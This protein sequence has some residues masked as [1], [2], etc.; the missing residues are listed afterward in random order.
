M[1]KNQ[2][3]EFNDNILSLRDFV[4]LIEPILIEKH[5]KHDSKVKPI[6]LSAMVHQLLQETTE[7]ENPEEYKKLI[8]LKSE[9]EEI[10]ENQFSE[11][12]GIEF[13]EIESNPKG[14][15]LKKLQITSKQEI[16]IDEHFR[17]ANKSSKHIDLLYRNS[18][19]SLLSSVEW[20]FAQILHFYFDKYPDSA[21]LGEKTLKLSEIKSFE[22]FKDAEIFLIENKIEDILRG[23]FESWM[24]ILKNTPLKLGL[25]YLNGR[26]NEIIEIYQR[27]NLIIHNGST[28]NSIYLNK[29]DSSL[30]Q[31]LKEGEELKLEKAY[32]DNSI[33]KLQLVFILIAA[34]LWK[35]L[36]PDDN[37]RGDIL[38]D[39]IYENVKDSRWEIA[40]GLSYFLIHDSKMNVTDKLVAQLNY[41]LSKKNQDQYDSVKSEIESADYSDKKEIFQLALAAL[42]E[43]KEEFFKLLPI[44]LDNKQLNIDRLEEFPVFKEMRGLEEYEAFKIN[45][46]YFK[47]PNQPIE[48]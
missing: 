24:N 31:N 40:E 18:L 15:T 28:I 41:W 9:V 39:I 12:I 43:D 1:F 8:E 16:D 22:S 47:E 29:V 34:E 36:D 27:R 14:I 46:G 5:E 17:N 30:I 42:K 38:N 20:F 45:T 19:I 21:G 13:D 48:N 10:I 6:V 3:T 26:K 2:I 23:N 7:T 4:D 11:K 35:K 44:T 37:D 33:C 25:G 32:L